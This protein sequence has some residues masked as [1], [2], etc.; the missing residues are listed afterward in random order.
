MRK[1][2]PRHH[3]IDKLAARWAD[4]R[5]GLCVGNYSMMKGIHRG[6]IAAYMLNW[7]TE[8][9]GLP[10]GTHKV[11]VHEK[12]TGP[13]RW[14]AGPTLVVD[15]DRLRSDPAYPEGVSAEWNRKHRFSPGE[16]VAYNSLFKNTYATPQERA[17]H[18]V[19]G[20]VIST[21]FAG[22]HACVDFENGEEGVECGPYELRKLD[23][24]AENP[25]PQSPR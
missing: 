20:V 14:S 22:M 15:F 24:S 7:L 25:N 17:R 18:G 12:R 16:R 9:G 2:S 10:T 3:L 13:M 6:T 1:R 5:Y 23:V 11:K 19:E 21:S 8:H 4:R